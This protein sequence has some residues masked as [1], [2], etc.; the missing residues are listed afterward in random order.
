MQVIR[1]SFY[2]RRVEYTFHY[3]N[4][5]KVAVQNKNVVFS[6][7]LHEHDLYK[8]IYESD[9]YCF[10]FLSSGIINLQGFLALLMLK[11]KFA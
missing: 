8:K 4:I 2:L 5:N 7:F 6:L 10:P 3:K 9:T 1:S 11:L